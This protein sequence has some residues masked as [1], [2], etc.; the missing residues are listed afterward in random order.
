MP[1]AA[2]PAVE[3]P[4]RGG[5]PL[6]ASPTVPGGEALVGIRRSSTFL[7]EL[8]SV[9][10]IAVLLVFAFHADVF[11]RFP[12]IEPK[13]TL[14]TA[15]VRAGYTGVDLFFLLSAFLL[16]LPFFVEAAGGRRVVLRDYFVRRTLLILPLFYSAVLVATVLCATELRDLAHGLPYLL[17][18]NSFPNMTVPFD[19]YSGVWWSLATEVQ[20]YLVLPLLLLFLRMRWGWLAGA[21]FI[22]AYALAYIA[23]VRGSLRMWTIVGQ[24]A[25]INSVFGRGPLFLWGI[26]A[27]AVFQH[28]GGWLRERLAQRRWLRMGGADLLLLALILANAFF[29]RWLVSIGA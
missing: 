24:M 25:F 15:F 17:F 16:S 18:L 22:G 5:G 3:E 13:S 14:A 8:E 21:A 2:D 29:L 12:F 7:P 28:A 23:M 11:I 27:A 26:F 9:R 20:F 19:P 1:P 10:G 4:Y 6:A